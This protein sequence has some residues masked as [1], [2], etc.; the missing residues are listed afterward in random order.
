MII[1]QVILDIDF[2][3]FIKCLWVYWFYFEIESYFVNGSLFFRLT[4][5]LVTCCV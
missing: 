4:A 5:W 2:I 1:K 3:L